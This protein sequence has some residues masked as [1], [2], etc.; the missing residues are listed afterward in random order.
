MRSGFRMALFGLLLASVAGCNRRQPN[1]MPPVAAQA[2]S[3]PGWEMAALMPAMPQLPPFVDDRPVMLDTSVPAEPVARP[4]DTHLKRTRRHPKTQE[5]AQQETTKP[6]AQTAAPSDTEQASTGQP[7]ETSPIGQLSTA[8]GDTNTGDRQALL[9]QI[10][11]TEKTLNDL[12]RSLSSEEQKT[13]TLIRTFIARARDAL[14]T[15]DLDGARS[16]TTKA[17]ILLQE[18]TKP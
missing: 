15:D 6:P 13:A 17:K 9:D 2:P 7:P 5:A 10:N 4:E 1:A 11:A 18:L 12:H 3:R 16:Y 14:K 8:G